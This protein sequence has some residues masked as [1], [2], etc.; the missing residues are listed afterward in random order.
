MNVL[1]KK[2]A[3]RTKIFLICKNSYEF[4]VSYVGLIRTK[5]VIFLINNSINEKKLNYLVNHYR[6]KYILAS[7]EKNI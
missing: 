3:K 5:A 1:G 4:V 6:P 7:K 2:I